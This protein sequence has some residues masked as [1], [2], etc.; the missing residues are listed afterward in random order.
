M[1]TQSTVAESEF[2]TIAKRFVAL[3]PEKKDVFEKSLKAKGLD[4]WALPIVSRSRESEYFPLSFAQERLWVLDQLESG[5]A[6]YNLFFGMRFC[7]ELNLQALE[8]SVNEIIRRHEVLR[9]NVVNVDG[10]GRQLIREFCPVILPVTDLRQC[11]LPARKKMLADMAR[12]EALTPFDLMNG[13]V[14]RIRVVR[15]QE[16]EHILMFTIHHIAFDAWSVGLMTDE[17]SRLYEA[18][19]QEKPSPLVDLPIQY[20]DFACWQREWLE[21]EHYETQSTYW[22]KQLQ[23]LV[24]RG[25]LPLDR[26]PPLLRSFEGEVE[27][28]TL[29]EALS[30]Q[31]YALCRRSGVTLYMLML[32]VYQLLISRYS[33]QEDVCVGTSIANRFR[34]ETE[35][36]IG[37]LV[38]TLVMR[39]SLTGD[40]SFPELLRR[41]RSVVTEALAHQ[42]LPFEKLV[43]LLGVTRD[44]HT[45]AL[46]QA[47][48]VL[49][50]V[51]EEDLRIANV[52]LE[53]LEDEDNSHLIHFDLTLRIAE[54]EEK[55]RIACHLEYARECFEQ[56]TAIRLLNHYHTL[57]EAAV[58]HPESRLSELSLLS[59]VE[60]RHLL[61]DL[62]DTH[63]PYP[64]DICIHDL[65]ESHATKNPDTP[66][67]RSE[68]E[69]L[70]YRELDRR[71]NQLA[72]RL[73]GFGVGPEVRV[74]LCFERSTDLVIGLLA[75]LK[76]GGAY[77]PLDPKLPHAR[78]SYMLANSHAQVVLTQ[79]QWSDVFAEQEMV[80]LCLDR[81][82]PEISALDDAPVVCG[83][84]PDNLAYVIYTSGSTGHPKGVAVEH[85]Q[86]VHY[87]SGVLDRLSL[88]D[89]ASFATVST[90]GADLG[91]TSI[92]GAL[93]SGRTLH[94]LATDRGFDPDAMAEYMHTH[95]VGVLKI[96]PTHLLG[97][98]DAAKPERVLPRRCLILGGEPVRTDLINTIRRLSSDCMIVNHYGPTETTVG[99]LI[100]QVEHSSGSE[101]CVPLG[102]PLPNVQ[103]YILDKDFQPTPI[104]LPGELY[105]AGNG[106]AR[107]YLQWSGLTAERFLP[108]PFTR[109][110]GGRLYRTGDRAR[111]AADGTIEFLGRGDHQVKFRGFRIELQEIESHLRNESEIK[112]AVVIV[113]ESAD[114]T[115]QLVAYLVASPA[116]DLAALRSRLGQTL[117]EYM[118][119]STIVVLPSLPLTFNGKVDRTALPAIEENS[120]T[121][122][123]EY[124]APRNEI[125]TRLAEIWA[126]VLRVEQV[127]I[128]DNFFDLGGDSI[129]SLQVI[130]RARK[131]EIIL[132]PK[133]LFE[134]PI[135]AELAV[136]AT[137]QHTDPRPL[138]KNV[139]R[140]QP[141]LLSYAQQRLWFLWQMDPGSA[142]YNISNAVRLMGGLRIQA[143]QQA[144]DMIVRRHE[145]LRTNFCEESGQVCQVIHEAKPVNLV[146][147]DL[148]GCSSTEREER[149]LALAE[150]EEMA[151]FDLEHGPLLRVVLL[152]LAETEHVLV[153]TMHHIV[154]DGWSMN[155]LVEEFVRLYEAYSQGVE[156]GLP[157]LTIQY[158]DY[159][160]WQRSWLES[161]ELGRQLEYWKGRLNQLPPMLELPTDRVRPAVQQYEGATYEFEVDEELT[162]KLKVLAKESNV[163]PFMFLLAAFNVLLFRYTGK[164]DILVGVPI[165]NRGPADTEGLIGI[166]VNSL[167]HRAD[168]RG[169]PRFQDVLQRVKTVALEAQEH[170]DLPFERLVEVINP[171]RNLSHH[172][173]F[174]VMY[175]HQ[176]RKHEA[177][178]ELTDLRIEGLASESH[179]TQFDLTLNTEES[180][181]QFFMSWTYST[182]L[183]DQSTVE[184]LARHWGH[185]LK[186]I[187]KNP[188]ERIENLPLLDEIEYGQVVREWDHT[189]LDNLS[190]RC[191]HELF[192]EQVEL[193]PGNVA[194]VC[195]GQSLTYAELNVRANRLAKKLVKLGVGSDM[196][197][198]LCVE[199]SLE[200][201]VALL[202]VLKAGGAYV[203]IDPDCPMERIAFMLADSQAA[204]LLTRKDL[205]Q[206]L[207]PGH[208]PVICLDEEEAAMPSDVEGERIIKKIPSD[209]LAYAIYTS[210][211]TGRSKGVM[212]SHRSAVSFLLSMQ[213]QL[214]PTERDSL[215]AV[216]SLSF[217]IALLELF[218]PLMV[219]AKVILAD[220][221]TV[222]DGTRLIELLAGSGPSFMQA[223]PATWRM[224]LDAGW[225]GMSGLKVLCGGEAMTTDLAA[226]MLKRGV[227]LWNVYGP[228]ET[229][230]WSTIHPVEYAAGPICIGR[231][232]ANTGIYILD[233]SLQPVPVG[234]PGELYIGGLGLARGYWNRQGLTAERFIPDPFG[235]RAGGRLY[236]TGDVGRWLPDGTVECF[237]RIDHQ[238]KIRG[239]RIEP[240]EIEARLVEHPGIREA[241]VLAREDQPG[242][243]RLVAYVVRGEPSPDASELRT[244]LQPTLPEYMIPSTVVFL[245]AMPLNTNGKID[246]RALPVP[247]NS[248]FDDDYVAPRTAAEEI[249]AGIW[250]EVLGVKTIGIRDNF[251][252]LGGHSLLATQVM[253]RL[254]AAFQVELPLR[255]LFDFPT[256][257]KLAGAV[258]RTLSGNASHG[259]PLLIPVTRKEHMPVSFAQQRLWFLSQLKPDGWSYNLPVALR[260]VGT[261]DIPALVNSVEAV[262]RRHETLRTTFR[263]VDGEPMQSIAVEGNVAM[264]VENLHDVSEDERH[265]AVHRLA[266]EEMRRPFRLDQEAPI[267]LRL[268]KLEQQEHVLLIVLHHIVADAWSMAL[269]A[270]EVGVFY[271]SCLYGNDAC[272]ASLNRLPVL[273]IQYADFAYWQR[274]WL[275][276]DVLE[277]HLSYWKQRLGANP[278]VLRLPTDRPRPSVQSYRGAR[279]TF[280]V[281]QSVTEKI[282]S[283]GRGNG[284]TLFMTLLAAFNVLLFRTTGQEDIIV[285][286]D[287]AN[288]NREETEGLI[289][290]FVNV[291]PFR[292]DL[293][294]N[295]TFSD[296]LQSVRE[297]ALEAYAH[298]DLPFEKVV[299]SLKITRD[300]G[301]NPLVQTL[302]VLQ[303]VPEPSMELPGLEVHALDLET[304]VSRFDL[305]LF[306]EETIEGLSGM[307]KYSL[308]LFNESTIVRLS[309]SF[310]TLLESI[311]ADPEARIRD[312]D[313]LS[314]EER[315]SRMMEHKHRDAVKHIKFKNIKPKAVPLQQRTLVNR[316]FLSSDDTLPMIIQPAVEDVD[317]FGWAKDNQ[318][319]IEKELLIHGA[320]LFRG[321]SIRK[322]EEFEEVIRAI[323]P[324]LFGQYGDLPREKASRHIYG[325]TPYPPDKPILFH[326]ES[327]HMHRWPLK[328]SFFCLQA[329]QEGGET[330]IVDC[331]EVYRR[332]PSEI[333]DRF[334]EK[335]LMYVRNF[336]PGFDVSWQDFFRTD[337]KAAVEGACRENG[338]DYTWLK[339]G[340]LQTRQICPAI[341]KHPKTGEWVFFN[342]V[343]LHHV[344]YLESTVR[345]SLLALLGMERLPRN[346]YFG[347]GSTIDD[348]VAREVG[349]IYDRTAV[350]FVWQAGDLLL[351]DNMLVAHAR[352]PYKGPRKI[353]VAM[354]EMVNQESLQI[355]DV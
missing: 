336:T 77:V 254:R 296:L 99:V 145:T 208:A 65:F 98:L 274:Q 71:A 222:H 206:S 85:R 147:K 304:E 199:R 281:S 348:A 79:M 151:P 331:R 173:L 20:V 149:V 251:F 123:Q 160:Q 345:D 180:A 339:D 171:Q 92:F 106:L 333:L 108:N 287:V 70:N 322:I 86:L 59:E 27:S 327:S 205:S 63:V 2:I 219:G 293:S 31:I 344:S 150:E 139:D 23:N 214:A 118:I 207:P 33:G 168:L 332:L 164:T 66:A 310:L 213:E 103:A 17:L 311:A 196:L 154:S 78:M 11:D 109:Q 220:R 325:T 129:V 97:L 288:R 51:P 253:S 56:S 143:L 273:P 328:Q 42:D 83:V 131:R 84:R 126:E 155:V 50:N 137:F 174:Q 167:V 338:V 52:T 10:Q 105:I 329:A 13:A 74:G 163:T 319:H 112:D 335:S 190:D 202:G 117:P 279:L 14:V 67:V 121:G 209:S 127:S 80:C 215:L 176:W 351:L 221:E 337:E 8:Q 241:V 15:C 324:N 197:V 347:D 64:Q 355:I 21:S 232:I 5:S 256:V 330:P 141:L 349:E 184:R 88:D 249:L 272:D 178:H 122:R 262:V 61:V 34:P 69:V 3:S 261:V 248:R 45:N 144:L 113:R 216:T 124:V 317:L 119:P 263:A 38:N 89:D 188:S 18:F 169:N 318:L 94:V 278:P 303:N 179:I 284:V 120:M 343:Q 308:D 298:Q 224:L 309:K 55:G 60:R 175:N 334:Y 43:D 107:G 12:T 286:T 57:L 243:K 314:D 4:I 146:V 192:E 265:E 276:G 240:G 186:G 152:R 6:R 252:E 96:T 200:A 102:R 182:N 321:F 306:M 115:P 172:P 301:S 307:W 158:A 246:R 326:N 104:G 49:E 16:T 185:L 116:L 48:F 342:Q 159:A 156:P 204:V 187:V 19:T 235:T 285:G 35:K 297:V 183:F 238:V 170:Q 26:T 95:D 247:E 211:S 142:A 218:L 291:L 225:E 346:V 341:T 258:E 236:R 90:V 242:D 161:G 128:Y 166:F 198:A 302:F 25:T 316:S 101:A 323:C 9:T 201:V 24:G 255:N 153:M 203:P 39:T 290:F 228:T 260:L 47:F 315:E 295:P 28:L 194:V 229:T 110:P 191:L 280:S 58:A 193:Y 136:L 7:G 44:L 352:D 87:I 312:L 68:E 62:N 283:I 234:V 130:A 340:G 354:G 244:Y 292:I 81:D 53:S 245:D 30:R 267:R 177:L 277:D 239:Y 230:V 237:G 226:Q 73:R 210:G 36:L 264:P 313:T 76:A 91:N 282:Q 268:L 72:R 195:K 114:R 320:I 231:P 111:Y 305:G 157:A 223:T 82:W 133:Q 148:S 189:C 165:A 250:T 259:T 100:H 271:A 299:E 37:F 227:R 134:C 32:A 40:P 140:T 233:G 350:R 29:S 294:G 212:I 270:H 289:G 54:D 135:I 275:Q 217:D 353:V 22:K 41:V 132:T 1:S 93:C 257:E 300:L 75:V 162:G 181:G 266:V 46:F 269:L 125:E 138:L